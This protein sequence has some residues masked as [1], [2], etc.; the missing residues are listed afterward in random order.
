MNLEELLEHEN[1]D[2][3]MAIEEICDSAG[4]SGADWNVLQEAGRM[5]ANLRSQL[6]DLS[7]DK[8]RLDWILL[9]T[10]QSRLG[11]DIKMGMEIKDEK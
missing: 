4:T 1:E 5:I 7:K 3:Q 10:S 8:E 9:Q 11:I 6:V 2:V